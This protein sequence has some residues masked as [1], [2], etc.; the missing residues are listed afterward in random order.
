MLRRE[1]ALLT[2][3]TQWARAAA[4]YASCPIHPRH[5]VQVKAERQR[6]QECVISRLQRKASIREVEKQRSATKVLLIA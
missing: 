1:N 5:G 3:L 2:R 6:T 4:S